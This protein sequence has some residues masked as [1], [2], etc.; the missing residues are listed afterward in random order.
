M[1]IKTTATE[2]DKDMNINFLANIT[3]DSY[4]KVEFMCI[5]GIIRSTNAI[6]EESVKW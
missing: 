4:I 6:N 3:W 2:K 1:Q 5:N